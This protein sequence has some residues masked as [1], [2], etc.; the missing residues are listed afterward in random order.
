MSNM[1]LDVSSAAMVF[2]VGEKKKDKRAHDARLL[3][4]MSAAAVDMEFER[5]AAEVT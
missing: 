4:K 5:S 2:A 3:L 1:N